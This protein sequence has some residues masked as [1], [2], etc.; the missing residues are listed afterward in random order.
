MK[1]LPSV[2]RSRAMRR[3]PSRIRVVEN[4]V[5]LGP[6]VPSVS[7]RLWSINRWLRWTGWRLFVEVPLERECPSCGHGEDEGPTTIGLVFCGWDFVGN[8]PAKGRWP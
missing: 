3:G 1:A 6:V 2:A 8:E 7:T 5:G 4:G